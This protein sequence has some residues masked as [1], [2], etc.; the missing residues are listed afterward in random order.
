MI[1]YWNQNASTILTDTAQHAQLVFGSLAIAL[2]MAILLVLLC[3]RHDRLLTGLNYIFS[4]LYSVPSFA[5]FA[6]LL[7]LTG[8][9]NTT[10]TVVLVIY[11]EYVILRT[12]ITGLRAIDPSLIEVATGMGMTSRQVFLKIQLPLAI[13]TIFSGLQVALASTMSI[14]TIAA[15]INAGGLGTLLFEGLQTQQ[16]PPLLWG[17]IMTV[18]LTLVS[19]AVLRI[20]QHVYQPRLGGNH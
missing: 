13:P 2:V 20:L 14:A 19:I 11:S 5:F 12:F 9:G 8:L 16:M 4:L 1:S 6:L 18:A 7:P 15:T 17:I 3:L 10:A